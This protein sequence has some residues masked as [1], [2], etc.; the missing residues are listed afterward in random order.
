MV[1]FITKGNKKLYDI[2]TMV[3]VLKVPKS[4][5]QRE[6]LKQQTEIIKYK[7]LHLYPEETF[8]KIIEIILIEKLEKAYD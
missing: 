2:S 6:L 8:F 5:I 3:E 1:E 4:K 7:N